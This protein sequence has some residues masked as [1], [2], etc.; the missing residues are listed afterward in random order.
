MDL[1]EVRNLASPT[2]FGIGF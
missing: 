1:G 2:D